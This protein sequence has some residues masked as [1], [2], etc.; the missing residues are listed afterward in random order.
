MLLQLVSCQCFYI[1]F[2]LNRKGYK[3]TSNSPTGYVNMC[4]H[5]VNSVIIL[6]KFSMFFALL[7]NAQYNPFINIM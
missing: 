6:L 5:L 7:F 4:C 1:F 2:L 3:D